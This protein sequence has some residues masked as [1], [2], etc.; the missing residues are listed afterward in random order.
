MRVP[1]LDSSLSQ[2]P[3]HRP[4]VNPHSSADPVHRPA[5]LVELDGF[6]YPLGRQ[7][8]HAHGYALS[9]EQT[10]HCLSIDPELSTQLVHRG[11]GSVPLDEL[12]YFVI[13]QPSHLTRQWLLSARYDR[14]V[15]V[16]RL[17]EQLLQPPNLLVGLE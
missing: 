4:R 7:A 1:Q 16:W 14:V 11:P 9:F 2:P 17:G 12:L 10:A 3:V 13:P 6:V 15:Q 5:S 8:L